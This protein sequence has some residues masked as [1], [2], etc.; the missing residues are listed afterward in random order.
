VTKISITIIPG[1]TSM[2]VIETPTHT[3]TPVPPTATHARADG[4]RDEHAHAAGRHAGPDGGT[5]RVTWPDLLSALAGLAVLGAI[6]YWYAGA[7]V[8]TRPAACAALLC[9]AGGLLASQRARAR[10]A[11]HGCVAAVVVELGRAGH[12]VAGGGCRPLVARWWDA[13]GAR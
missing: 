9:A 11:R 7:R 8:S 1:A 4:Q 6:G 3:P 13:G 2:V 5:R 10:F 12:Y